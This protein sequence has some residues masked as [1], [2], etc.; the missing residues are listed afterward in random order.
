M[1]HRLI[2]LKQSFIRIAE[3]MAI[4]ALVIVLGEL[5]LSRSL[6]RNTNFNGGYLSILEE[7]A[8][9]DRIL[10]FAPHEDDEVLGA[11]AY[12]QRALSV[13]AE[14]I[15]CLITNGEYPEASVML[16]ERTLS[17]KPE[18][19]IKYGYA[20]QKETL[21]AL[22]V[23]GLDEGS[24]LF[25]GY[26]DHSIDKLLSPSHWQDKDA[27][28]SI[29]TRSTFS[30]YSNSFTP[31]TPHSGRSLLRDIEDILD[32]VKPD[33]VVAVHPHDIHIDHWST[34]AFVKMALADA[35]S[36]WAG[37]KSPQLINYMV[38]RPE[39]PAIKSRRPAF[40][41]VPPK[42]FAGL[43]GTHWYAFPAE[44]SETILKNIA[45]R[46]YKSQLSSLS[47]LLN[48][49]VRANELFG[50][51]PD[52]KWFMSMGEA[53][54][55]LPGEPVADNSICQRSPHADI[56]GMRLALEGSI[57]SVQVSLAKPMTKAVSLEIGFA[58]G[59][60]DRHTQVGNLKYSLGT[61]TSSYSSDEI[62][63]F[64]GEDISFAYSSNMA[65]FTFPLPQKGHP[66]WMMIWCRSYIGLRNIDQSLIHFIRFM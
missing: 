61:L 3:L 15:V 25:L 7:P 31:S 14:V 59:G 50:V 5:M 60:V 10:V 2:R 38:Q 47:P 8:E 37:R 52:Q 1:H 41:L 40:S 55:D 64:E 23:L 49:F 36:R 21:E 35:E 13:G 33:T 18:T 65:K 6:Y 51:V 58:Q 27:L 54:L 43:D 66:G 39:W 11:G 28:M 56:S 34:Y 22:E 24:V 57:I 9:G 62:G 26:P 42:G 53:S 46:S 48:S 44:I 12:I 63:H 45:L 30:P 4:A 17:A 32:F 29:R 20:R 16:Q 19:F